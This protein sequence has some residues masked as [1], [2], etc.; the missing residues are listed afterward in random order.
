MISLQQQTW[1]QTLGIALYVPRQWVEQNSEQST[2]DNSEKSITDIRSMINQSPV[3]KVVEVEKQQTTTV[4]PKPQIVAINMVCYIT[5]KLCF[6]EHEN[7]KTMH[8]QRQLMHNIL[9]A[10]GSQATPKTLPLKV[11]RDDFTKAQLQIASFLQA[12]NILDAESQHFTKTVIIMGNGLFKLLANNDGFDN[13]IGL[14][15]ELTAAHSA[16]S[17]SSSNDPLKAIVIPSTLTMLKDTHAKKI[18]W[19]VLKPFAITHSLK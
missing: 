15:T 4:Q 13:A 12:S 16:W 19:S 5:D 14:N 6:I 8:S 3:A 7:P 1:L 11:N 9:T 10:L 17:L 18:A 2:V